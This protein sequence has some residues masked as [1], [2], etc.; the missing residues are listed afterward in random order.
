MFT[1]LSIQN[2][3]LVKSVE[4]AFAPGLTAITGESGAGKSLLVAAVS[5]VL[6]ARGERRMVRPGESSLHISAEFVLDPQGDS[7]AY[8]RDH[9]LLDQ[10]DVSRLWV[11]RIV[12]AD[13]GS[14]AW[15][16]GTSVS[17][18]ALREICASMVEVHGQFEQQLLLDHR[19]Q[20]RWLDDFAETSQLRAEAGSLYR[21][22]RTSEQELERIRQESHRS[23][24]RL[25][26]LLYQSELLQELALGTDEF[27]TLQAR[28]KRLARAGELRERLAG[29]RRIVE[30]D[31]ADAIAHACQELQS[32]D[33]ADP[34]L[35]QAIELLRTANIS[36]DEARS[37]LRTYSDGI[38]LDE[39]ALAA[40]EHRLD[41]VFE[42]SRRLKVQPR[43]LCSLAG[44]IRV[45]LAE[46]ALESEREQAAAQRTS[47][48]E[49]DFRQRARELSSRRREAAREFRKEVSLV[50]KR[51][52][53]PDAHIELKFGEAQGETG[54]DRVDYL[55]TANRGC[56]PAP[57]SQVASGGELARISL[58]I[59]MVAAKRSRLPCMIL[60]EADLGVS[61]TTA[62]VLGRTLHELA[63]NTQVICVTHAAQVAAIAD[64]HLRVHKDA[65]TDIKLFELSEDDR[66]EEVAR[67]VGGRSVGEDAREYARTLLY[68]GSGG[69]SI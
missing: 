66:V 23:K 59:Q 50:L 13:G 48:A 29:V 34:A 32:I 60:D 11:R 25:E 26:S 58:A 8:L 56:A 7:A 33:D 45:D 22:W 67:M 6:G 4:M 69:N 18:S 9:E 41:Q 46:H 51:I 27:D 5:M 63:R 55:V 2:F 20:L 57:I 39:A 62:D 15:V 47:R 35:A 37:D 17:V 43:E 68:D 14:R 40:V 21:A 54:L 61:G 53:L 19:T 44:R 42:T 3:T 64:H 10:D 36:L 1:A 28:Y 38:D 24:E 49:L 65:G 16:N 12:R 31:A 30:G 52:G